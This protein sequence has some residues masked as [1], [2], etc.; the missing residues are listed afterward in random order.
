MAETEAASIR[1]QELISMKESPC[2][3]IRVGV[4]KRG[5]NGLS[6]VIN[7]V[8]DSNKNALDEIVEERGLQRA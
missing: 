1:I 3:G 8:D 7:Y 2:L 4:R 5:C 6:Y